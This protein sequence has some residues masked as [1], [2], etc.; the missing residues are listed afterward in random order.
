MQLTTEHE[1]DLMI[2]SVQ[3]DRLDAAGAVAF[4]DAMKAA[5]QDAP[6]RVMLNLRQVRFLDSSGLGAI[7]STMKQLAP[8]RRL[9]VAALQPNV[10]RV[11][12]L[13][14]MDTVIDVHATVPVRHADLSKVS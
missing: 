8:A 13:T 3:E 4:K 5:T 1:P 10:M 2:V 12:R 6:E 7:V 14:R 11:F 9:E